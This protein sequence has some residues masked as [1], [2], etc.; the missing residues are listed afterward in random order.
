[1]HAFGLSSSTMTW[2]LRV[3]LML[4]FDWSSGPWHRV[5]IFM[6]LLENYKF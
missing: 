1:M 5:D 2:L 4:A 3:E 6:E